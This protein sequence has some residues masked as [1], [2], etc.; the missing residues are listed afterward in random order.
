[1]KKLLIGFILLLTGPLMIS[2]LAADEIQLVDNHPDRHVVVKGD[3]LWDIS[4][5]F[6]KSPWLWPKVWSVNP[7]IDNPHLIYPGDVVYLVY[8]NGVPQ[9]RLDRSG[10]LSPQ[11]RRSPLEQAIRAIPLQDVKSF[12]SDNLVLSA[13]EL[14]AAPYVLGGANSA[15]IAGAGDRVYARGTVEQNDQNFFGV[16]RPARVYIDPDTEEVLGYESKAIGGGYLVST[17]KDIL[18]LDLKRTHEEVRVKDRV[19]PTPETVIQ[20]VF[21]P[22][23]PD[24]DVSGK[25]MSV[26]KGVTQIGQFDV[27]AINLG[28]REGMKPG[29]VLHVFKKGEIVKDP[30]TGELLT[31]PSELGG[32]VMVFKVFD[33]V[34]YALV[35]KAENVLSVLDEVH[36]P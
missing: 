8:V 25:I 30:V 13:D 20:S 12:L 26:L 36:T 33:K 21:Y 15:I 32:T 5:T 7:Q 16:Y 29:H 10:K 14:Q 34:S 28:D 3:T 22:S 19:L 31:L 9:L 6:L 2:Q 35:M 18:T 1:M 17:K 4:A 11:I 27:V 23:A 24:K